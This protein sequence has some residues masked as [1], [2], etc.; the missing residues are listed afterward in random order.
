MTT[1]P[2]IVIEHPQWQN[3]AVTLICGPPG[4]GKTTLGLELHPS[5]LD[6]GEMPPGTP[7][8]R[9]KAYG[10]AAHRIGRNLSADIAVVRGAPTLEERTHQQNLCRPSKTV[11]LLT[12]AATCHD[13]VT[14]RDR[15][16][17]PGAD[18]RGLSEQHGAIDSWWIA[19]ES[20]Q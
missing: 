9:M 6:I 15:S 3:R 2:H 13:R 19:W 12:D 7:R 11:V 20:D 8:Q 10:K 16:P 4:S 18:G 1:D 17:E 5:T 14:K